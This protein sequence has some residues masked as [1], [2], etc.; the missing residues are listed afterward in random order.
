MSWPFSWMLIMMIKKWIL[1]IFDSNCLSG[2]KYSKMVPVNSNRI[3][4]Q[5][6][7]SDPNSTQN[8]QVPSPGK[9]VQMVLRIL[10]EQLIWQTTNY[11]QA[12]HHQ[13]WQQE[14]DKTNLRNHGRRLTGSSSTLTLSMTSRVRSRF[15]PWRTMCWRWAPRTLRSQQIVKPY[16][17]N[18]RARHLQMTQSIKRKAATMTTMV[19]TLNIWLLGSPFQMKIWMGHLVQ[20]S[21]RSVHPSLNRNQTTKQCVCRGEGPII[22]FSKI[23]AWSTR[24]LAGWRRWASPITTWRRNS[25]SP[26]RSN[27]WSVR[28]SLPFLRSTSGAGSQATR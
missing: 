21:D 15:I 1:Q 19:A 20:A 24:A 28:M 16:S 8:S 25:T 3:Q 14:K 11:T 2:T 4:N 18:P 23:G 22:V 13:Q 27:Y 26:S 9:R 17:N 6:M 12:L 10:C 7:M 5:K